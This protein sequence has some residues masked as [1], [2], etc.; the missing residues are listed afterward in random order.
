MF[1][2]LVPRNST[3]PVAKSCGLV[4][5]ENVAGAYR[6]ASGNIHGCRGC[7]GSA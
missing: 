1:C 6:A 4:A 2:P 5:A 3:P 7:C